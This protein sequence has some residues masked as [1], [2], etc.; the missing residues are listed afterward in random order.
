MPQRY[1]LAMENHR[2]LPGQICAQQSWSETNSCPKG[3]FSCQDHRTIAHLDATHLTDG[4]A[5]ST[6]LAFWLGDQNTWTTISWWRLMMWIV[7]ISQQRSFTQPSCKPASVRNVGSEILDFRAITLRQRGPWGV[8]FELPLQALW[9]V[10]VATTPYMPSEIALFS[11]P[12]VCAPRATQWCT[13]SCNLW[14]TVI[15]YIYTDYQLESL[16]P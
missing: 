16:I 10:G 5:Q 1:K 15:I 4:W 7:D 3:I 13:T 12:G 9:H 6:Q 14:W 2:L 8:A 11:R